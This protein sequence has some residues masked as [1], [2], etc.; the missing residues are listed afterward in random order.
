VKVG[1]I[2]EIIIIMTAQPAAFDLSLGG[3]RLGPM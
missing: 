3:S 1:E 2:A